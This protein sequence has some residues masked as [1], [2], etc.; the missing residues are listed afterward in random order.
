[1]GIVGTYINTLIPTH[2]LKSHPDIRLDVLQQVAQV[3]SAIC[4]GQG[5][6]YEDVSIGHGPDHKGLDSK[7][8][9]YTHASNDF[10]LISQLKRIVWRLRVG[11]IQID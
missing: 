10:H 8:A 5:A 1:V 6:R 3:D 4:V 2:P 9:K 7:G 11:E